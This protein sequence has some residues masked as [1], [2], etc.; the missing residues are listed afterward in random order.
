VPLSLGESSKIDWDVACCIPTRIRRGQ[1]GGDGG[2]PLVSNWSDDVVNDKDERQ[3][4]P[5]R[6]IEDVREPHLLA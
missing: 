3:E 2:K 4:R 6:A 1:P 5:K